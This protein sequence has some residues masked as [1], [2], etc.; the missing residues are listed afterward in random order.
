MRTLP[1]TVS[2]AMLVGYLLAWF[3]AGVLWTLVALVLVTAG[4]TGLWLL[5]ERA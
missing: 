3:H 2:V 4:G 1:I 5:D